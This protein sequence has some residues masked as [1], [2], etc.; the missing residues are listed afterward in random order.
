MKHYE[1]DPELTLSD[2]GVSC[3]VGLFFAMKDTQSIENARGSRRSEGRLRLLRSGNVLL[4]LT[5]R[6]RTGDVRF[7]V[8][9]RTSDDELIIHVEIINFSARYLRISKDRA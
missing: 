2:S 7:G 5:F 1:I 8:L 9:N 3:R 6:Q 4:S